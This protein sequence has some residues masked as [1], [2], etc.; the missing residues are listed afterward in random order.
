MNTIR[1]ALA[2]TLKD[3]QIIFMG[4]RGTLISIFVLPIAISIFSGAIFGGDDAGINIPV[5][6]VNQDAGDYGGSIVEVLKDSKALPEWMSDLKETHLLETIDEKSRKVYNILDFPW[7]VK[8]RD[9]I[10]ISR[11]TVDL[12]MGKVV[13][14]TESIDDA[15]IPISKDYVRIKN[16]KQQYVLE[17]V[18]DNETRV[19]YMVHLEPGGDLSASMVNR[20]IKKSPRNALLGMK[21]M[22]K[23]KKYWK[24]S[25]GVVTAE[26]YRM[27]S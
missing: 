19:T 21:K 23:K 10:L 3:L 27:I 12:N 8:D 1:K 15:T 22:V 13:I 16:L 2:V 9:A 26:R 4:D 25:A 7:P 11:S 20:S 24:K 6:V 5:V 18:S 14:N 17:Y